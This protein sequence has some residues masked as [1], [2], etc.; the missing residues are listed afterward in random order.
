MDLF[1]SPILFSIFKTSLVS[2]IHT[3]NA[4]HYLCNLFYMF[5]YVY[6]MLKGMPAK[7]IF[8]NSA[9][10]QE[11]RRLEIE[12]VI[13]INGQQLFEFQ[14]LILLTKN[15]KWNNSLEIWTI[16]KRIASLFH[17]V[18]SRLNFRSWILQT[19]DCELWIITFFKTWSKFINFRH[20]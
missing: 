3:N 19:W 10:C 8:P 14:R 5:A 7:K 6:K 20:K 13:T 11:E 12:N 18:S 4:I 2:S 16:R 1:L 15:Q 17:V 9:T